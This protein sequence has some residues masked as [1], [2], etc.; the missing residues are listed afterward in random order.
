MIVSFKWPILIINMK[1][2]PSVVSRVSCVWS[3]LRAFMVAD[4]AGTVPPCDRTAAY[5]RDDNR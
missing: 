5:L 2:Q 1:P 4:E 3:H